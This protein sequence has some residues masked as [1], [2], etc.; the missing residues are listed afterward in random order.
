MD[1]F[2]SLVKHDLVKQHRNV[3]KVWQKQICHVFKSCGEW[4][5]CFA[6]D[7]F[8]ATFV[9]SFLLFTDILQPRACQRF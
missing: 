7:F 3:C 1:A 2:S 8:E 4:H 9:Q 6:L 5:N